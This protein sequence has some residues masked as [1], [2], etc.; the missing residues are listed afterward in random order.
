MAN[1]SDIPS[2]ELRPA[3]NADGPVVRALVFAT[4]REFGLC[5]EPAA[6][7]SD[8]DDIESSY[9]GSGGWFAVLCEPATGRV[10][11][12]AGLKPRGGGV[13]E[14]RKMYLDPAARGKGLGR[15][16]LD[17]AVRHAEQAGFERIVLETATALKAAVRLYKRNGFVPS[18]E[19]AHAT[20]CEIVMERRLRNAA[21]EVG[22]R[23]TMSLHYTQVLGPIYGW[24]LG[25]FE[26]GVAR[27]RALFERHGLSE[28]RGGGAVDLGAGNGLQSVALARLGFETT[29]VDLCQPLLDELLCNSGGLAIK[30]VC[31][32]ILD[33]RR[34]ISTTPH[35]IVCMGDTLTHLPSAAAVRRLI[36]DAAQTLAPGG[37]LFLAFR[38]YT[39]RPL[40]GDARFIPVRSDSDRIHTCFLEYGPETVR[41]HDLVHS[42]GENGWTQ[43]VGSYLKLR[44][45]PTLVTA[46]MKSAGLE[47]SAEPVER[48]MLTLVGRK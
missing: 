17:A 41:V 25:D 34:A 46:W 7:D 22:V 16:L 45:D 8:L 9:F 33:F 28:G 27:N 36:E 44:L 40:E 23:D 12:T 1:A 26:A 43:K 48:G 24:M 47:V 6:T 20:R 4:L 2:Y 11:G 42:R 30:T 5:P 21:A 32:D 19:P 10:V 18:V 14:L 39:S 38:D 35:V 31:G 3:T 15:V 13:V 37:L 29:A